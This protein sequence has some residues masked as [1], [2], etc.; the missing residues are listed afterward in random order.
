MNCDRHPSGYATWIDSFFPNQTNPQIIGFNA[1]PDGDGIP[2]G[3]EALS[4]GN[5]NASGVFAITELTKTGNAFTLRYPQ[6]KMLPG[7]LTVG[8]EWSTD[9]IHWQNGDASFGGVTVTLADN[10]WD[11]TDPKV[12]IY[13]VAATVTAGSASKLFVRVKAVKP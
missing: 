2:N 12:N 3:I 4:G 7:D 6:D 13:Q 5:P 10:L 11:D 9:M 1:D 8:Y